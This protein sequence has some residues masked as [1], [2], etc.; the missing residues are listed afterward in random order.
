M[1]RNIHQL[2]FGGVMLLL[3]TACQK[4]DRP[5]LGDYAKDANE[6]GGPLNFYAAFDG[7][8]S[9][10]QRN[11]VDS[12]RANFA[13]DNPLVSVDGVRGKGIKGSAGKFVKYQKPNDWATK[14]KG[15]TVSFWYKKDGQTQNNIG[16]NGPEFPF[17]FKSSNGHWSGSNFML[18]LEG[19]NTACAV[20]MVI[21]DKNMVDPWFTWEGAGAIAGLLNNQ[22]RHMALVYDASASVLTLYVDGVPNPVTKPWGTHGDVNIDNSKISELRIGAGP[23]T[24]YTTDD[25]LSSS[26]K[27]DL[28]QF[29]LYST[30]LSAAEIG[31]LYSG[32]K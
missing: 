11:A 7:T 12:I 5:A 26:W 19:N 1:K 13:S 14:A 4:M 31:A 2:I 27:G 10:A 23:G 21:V 16:T 20:K 24:G 9:N 8:T 18:M 25:W 29:R 17:S 15:F 32:K 22:W 28:D 3:F 30:A 6:P